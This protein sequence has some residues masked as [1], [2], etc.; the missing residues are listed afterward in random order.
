MDEIVSCTKKVKNSAKYNNQ[1]L[2]YANQYETTSDSILSENSTAN[3][4]FHS[5]HQRCYMEN[6]F[7]LEPTL[8]QL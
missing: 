1:I 4:H 5:R 7:I 8:T 6:L 3:V 2:Q